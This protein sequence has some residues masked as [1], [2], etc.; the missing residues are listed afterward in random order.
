MGLVVTGRV[1]K[2]VSAD[3][4]L[5]G[6]KCTVVGIAIVTVGATDS[7]ELRDGGA[8]GVIKVPAIDADGIIFIPMNVPF[9]TDLYAN[10]TGT[11]ARYIVICD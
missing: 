7:I 11:T 4:T 3:G 8:A 2:A 5:L 1:V 10:V 9:N 6:R